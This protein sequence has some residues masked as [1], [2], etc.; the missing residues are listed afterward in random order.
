MEKYMILLLKTPFISIIV[1]TVLSLI[2]YP[3]QTI[4]EIQKFILNLPHIKLI[5]HL[6]KPNQDQ[7]LNRRM[8][9]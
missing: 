2:S 8:E 7:K 5:D 9:K 4:N 1:V 6:L 3:V